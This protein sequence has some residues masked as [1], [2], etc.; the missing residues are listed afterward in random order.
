MFLNNAS[1]QVLERR[2]LLAA[3][4]QATVG[5]TIHYENINNRSFIDSRRMAIGRPVVD[6]DFLV[7][8]VMTRQKPLDTGA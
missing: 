5:S 3:A 4:D 1:G 2:H 6:L 8:D 7:R